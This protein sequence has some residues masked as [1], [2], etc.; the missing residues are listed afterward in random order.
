MEDAD[1][2]KAEGNDKFKDK[3]FQAAVDAYTR[4][5]DLNPNQHLCYSNRCAAYL[6]VGGNDD[7]ALADAEK[8]VELMPTWTKGYH[9][10]CEAL[11]ALKRSGEATAVLE[12]GMTLLTGDDRADLE[13]RLE[14]VPKWKFCDVLMST[15]HGTVNEVLG[16]YDQEMEFLDSD[17]VRIEVLGRSIIGK[18]AVDVSHEPHHLNI[19]VPVGEVP[20]GMPPP[21]PVPYIARV[22]EI[23]LHL[24]CPYLKMERPAE[25]TGPGYVLMKAGPLGKD[26]N[27]DVTNLSQA[28][29]L[30]KCCQE[31]LKVMP[32]RKLD[33]VNAADSEDAAGEKLMAQVRFESSMFSVVKIFGEEVVKQVLAATRGSIP[34]ELEGVPELTELVEKLRICGI[35]EEAGEAGAQAPR[36]T[37]PSV[38]KPKIAAAASA[39]ASE[40]TSAAAA[41]QGSS[42]EAQ[43]SAE[44]GGED[45]SSCSVAVGGV[46]LSATVLAAV[47]FMLSRKQRF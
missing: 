9:R 26:D 47:A 19:V 2:A 45:G 23:G 34:S 21:P 27:S 15:W 41:T 29:K 4:S 36:A 39:M 38:E 3:D 13:K 11:R 28:E 31:L 43:K 25:F 30:Q 42:Q 14:L 10:V 1:K 7:K 44:G 37:P 33:D 17:S 22:D 24:C 5:L 40:R 32:N 20:P 6:K 8:C 46:L 35:L 16:G 12:K 18:Y